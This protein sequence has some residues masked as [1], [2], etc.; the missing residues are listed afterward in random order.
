MTDNLPVLHDTNL[1]MKKEH[2]ELFSDLVKRQWEYGGIKYGAGVEVQCR[3]STD[4][5]TEA[6]GLNGLLWTMAK[7]LFRF[8][9][10]RREKDLLK[11][12]CYCFILW[13]KLGYWGNQEHDEDVYNEDDMATVG[14]EDDA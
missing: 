8:R 14:G 10:L 13:L 12:S 2:W 6:F 9:N 4:I 7:Y 5:L 3:E 1:G 11:L